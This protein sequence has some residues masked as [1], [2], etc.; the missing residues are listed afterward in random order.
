MDKRLCVTETEFSTVMARAKRE[1]STPGTVLRQAWDA[2]TLAVLTRVA[3]KAQVISPR[4]AHHPAWE[5]TACCG[6]APR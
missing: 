1:G 3:Y 2:R 5:V 6:G 4:S